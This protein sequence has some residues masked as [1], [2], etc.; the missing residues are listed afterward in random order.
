MLLRA[1]RASI[2]YS[3]LFGGLA[4]GFLF[5]STLVQ[6]AFDAIVGSVYRYTWA[7]RKG[8][9]IM[10]LLLM[11]VPTFFGAKFLPLLPGLVLFVCF[12]GFIGLVGGAMTASCFQVW[13]SNRMRFH[14][15]KSACDISDE[16]T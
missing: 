8:I 16:P 5:I 12:Y 4:W 13:R 14:T 11:M 10:S 9:G 15:K 3:F 2:W 6:T 7:R 1:I